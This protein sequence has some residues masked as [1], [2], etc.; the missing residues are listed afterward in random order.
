MNMIIYVVT[1]Y[2]LEIDLAGKT[3]E[4]RGRSDHFRILFIYFELHGQLYIYNRC[5]KKKKNAIIERGEE[6]KSTKYSIGLK[7]CLTL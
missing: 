1:H 3:F 4:T 2:F 6:K 7:V 5:A